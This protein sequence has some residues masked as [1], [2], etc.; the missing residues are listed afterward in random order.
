[1]WGVAALSIQRWR[2]VSNEDQQK[3]IYLTEEG[4]S[5]EEKHIQSAVD[6]LFTLQEMR[7]DIAK[8]LD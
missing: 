8:N 7:R 5:K 2:E 3:D 1:M 4:E 6:A